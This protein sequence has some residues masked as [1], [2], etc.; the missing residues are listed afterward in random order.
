MAI[1][2]R[3]PAGLR[4]ILRT[5]LAAPPVRFVRTLVAESSADDVPGIGAEMAYRFLF[6][7]FPFLIFLAAFVGFIGATVGSENLFTTVMSLIGFLLPSEVREVVRGWMAR[8][9]D[10]QWRGLLTAGAV[11]ALWGAAGGVGSLIK[12]LNRAY[13]V[14]E[15]RPF[16][17]AQIL[18]L[19]TTVALAVV[20]MG[21][22]ILYTAGGWLGSTLATIL[23]LGPGFL[24]LW[25]L[26]RGPGVTLGLG[27]VL[28]ALYVVLPNTQV[29]LRAAAPGAAFATV[30]WMALTIGFSVYIANFG[31]Y[32]RTFGSLGAAVMLMVW[33]YA[34]A[35]I[36][37]IGGEINA[38]LL[39]QK[40]AIARATAG[41]VR[42][43]HRVEA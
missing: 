28:L 19:G 12:G 14:P 34:V 5:M 20:M 40:A 13:D 21:G 42:A 7:L 24:A 6:A 2:D 16:W 25:D 33:M 23:G 18:A 8:V 36:L 31:A 4:L 38:V 32:E 15:S 35:L 1:T 17:K 30:G 37:L 9:I 10:V 41:R 26:L 39:Q 29:S 27:I 3:L 11:G 22:V 43:Q